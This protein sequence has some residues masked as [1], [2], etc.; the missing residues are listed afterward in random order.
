MDFT[1]YY[2]KYLKYKNKYLKLKNTIDIKNNFIKDNDLIKSK[3][4]IGGFSRYEK[5][6]P[7]CRLFFY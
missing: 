4:Q 1:N 6:I 3:N 2:K 5:N 7:K